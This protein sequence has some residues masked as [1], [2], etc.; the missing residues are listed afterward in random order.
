MGKGIRDSDVPRAK[1]YVRDSLLLP[2]NSVFD[3]YVLIYA[4]NQ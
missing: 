2:N 1:I 4:D 3:R